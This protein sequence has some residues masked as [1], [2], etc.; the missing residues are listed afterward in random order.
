MFIKI[1]KRLEVQVVI[2]LILAI[3]VWIYFGDFVVYISW[4]WEIFMKM[5]K[6]FLVPLLLFSI[7]IAVLWLW[8]INKLWSIWLRTMWYY[9]LTTT[10]AILLSL[11]IMNTFRPWVWVSIFDEFSSSL[12]SAWVQEWLTFSNFIL[13]LIPDNVVASFVE[14]NAIQIVVIWII[15]SIFIMMNA[16]W[17]SIKNLKDLLQTLNKWILWFIWF[18]VKLTPFGVFAIVSNIVAD[19]WVDSIVWLLPLVIISI[20]ALFVH[21]FVTLPIMWYLIWKFNPFNYF[22]KVKDAIVLWFSTSSSSATMWTSMS[23]ARNNAKLSDEVVDFTFPLW[24]TINMDGT[25]LYQALTAL[26]VSQA[27]WVDLTILQQMTVVVIIILA[28]VWAAWIPW[29]WIIIL[30]TVF[31]SIWLP[32]EA[33]WIILAVDRLLD[34]FRTAVNVW[35]DLLTAKVVDT[36]YVKNLQKKTLT[37]KIKERIMPEEEL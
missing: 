28:S 37:E 4:M 2:S 18:V 26:F 11:A 25:A 12:N 34:M 21:S 33:I 17:S 9:M 5:L 20:I 31:I 35:W 16:S 24:T 30:T 29:A 15:L 14:L 3:I 27:L 22:L 13:S 19:S 10:L 7:M 6:V 1:L 23:V 32:V 8:D 36:F